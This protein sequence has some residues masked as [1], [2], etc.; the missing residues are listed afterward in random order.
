MDADHNA[1]EALPP[2]LST[3]R[4]EDSATKSST[5]SHTLASPTSVLNPTTNTPYH[6]TRARYPLMSAAQELEYQRIEREGWEGEP[7]P[8]PPGAVGPPFY[9]PPMKMRLWDFDKEDDAV[10]NIPWVD[11]DDDGPQLRTRIGRGSNR[12][13]RAL[14]SAGWIDRFLEQYADV[15]LPEGQYSLARPADIA[16]G[17]TEEDL[18]ATN[19]W[20]GWADNMEPVVTNINGLPM[21]IYGATP[22]LHARDDVPLQVIY[23]PAGMHDFEEIESHASSADAPDIDNFDMDYEEAYDNE[24]HD[25]DPPSIGLSSPARFPGE[26]F[27][28]VLDDHD[29]ADVVPSTTELLPVWGD[30]D[31][32]GAR[33]HDHVAIED[34]ES[35]SFLD[36]TPARPLT[37]NGVPSTWEPYQKYIAW[38][39]RGTLTQVTEFVQTAFSFEPPISKAFVGNELNGAH[40]AE[41]V[42]FLE[43]Y[44]PS[45]TATAQRARARA[46]MHSSGQFDP[47]VYDGRQGGIAE[48]LEVTNSLYQR[49]PMPDGAPSDWNRIADVELNSFIGGEPEA[50]LSAYKDIAGTDPSEEV[51]AWIAIRSAQTMHLGFSMGEIAEALAERER[52]WEE[53][54]EDGDWL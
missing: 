42:A 9:L 38:A 35:Y 33:A 11:W 36:W 2:N 24:P 52:R 39:C 13:R 10:Q 45:E 5:E 14:Q 1:G 51:L 44:L 17:M 31:V 34:E 43:R 25:E 54:Q 18:H 20:N 7:P 49:P 50:F 29:A 27:S 22:D 37:R 28:Q 46:N 15:V 53:A 16:Q 6:F 41:H 40:A 3:L 19:G 21:E 32:E 30:R 26:W 4:L 8:P 12:S 47:E 23:S 48:D